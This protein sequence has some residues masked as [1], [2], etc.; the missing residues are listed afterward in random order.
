MYHYGRMLRD[1]IELE[2]VEKEIEIR[3]KMGRMYGELE[4]KTKRLKMR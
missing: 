4:E 3:K 1:E 2:K